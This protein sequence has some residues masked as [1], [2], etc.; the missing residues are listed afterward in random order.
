MALSGGQIIRNPN[1]R[2]QF[3][4]PV[5]WTYYK[6]ALKG[7]VPTGTAYPGQQTS[8]NAAQTAVQNAVDLSVSQALRT[9]NL[10]TS[11]FNISYGGYT[12][13]D[14][15]IQE[16]PTNTVIGSYIVGGAG[17]VMKVRTQA[18]SDTGTPFVKVALI[19]NT[20]LF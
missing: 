14:I 19:I 18:N 11:G 5:G 20:I 3:S 12:P 6:D 13:P 8:L 17:A 9:L 10:P 1:F 16:G 15:L 7:A 4:P 2:F